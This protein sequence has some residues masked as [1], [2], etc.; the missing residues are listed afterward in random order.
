MGVLHGGADDTKEPQAFAYGQMRAIP[1]NRYAVDE[2][3]HDVRN[4]L[5]ARPGVNDAGDVRMI[6]AREDA[7]LVLETAQEELRAEL[8]AD[9]LDGD[10]TLVESVRTHGAV[11][12][13]HA[14]LA[15]LID[16]P[17]G[18]QNPTH[19]APGVRAFQ[20]FI[21]GLYIWRL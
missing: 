10:R 5:L 16:D 6:E 7:A 21:A 18:A 12:R 9:R 19:P 1:V 17:I 4:A 20:G 2:F 11:N 3:H 14:A 13:A 8:A 15:H